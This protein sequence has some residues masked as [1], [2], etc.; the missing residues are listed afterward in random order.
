MESPGHRIAAAEYDF[1]QA[2][3]KASQY[4]QAA[5]QGQMPDAS[6]EKV[7]T[8]LN[9]ARKFQYSRAMHIL[10]PPGYFT[11]PLEEILRQLENLH[12]NDEVDFEQ[13]A[14]EDM[15]KPD[16]G[17]FDFIDGPWLDKQI[18][19]SRAGAVLDQWGW[20]IKEMW[21]PL[22]RDPDLLHDIAIHWIKPLAV[23]STGANVIQINIQKRLKYSRYL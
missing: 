3:I 18:Q 21:A 4:E 12:P 14:Q 16:K 7:D 13:V 22:R 15:P 2:N 8:V 5:A 10:R 9:M 23:G 11:A 17:A 6:K 20:D 19:K 1:E